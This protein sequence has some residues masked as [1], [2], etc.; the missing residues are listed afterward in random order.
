M[1]TVIT[2]GDDGGPGG[3]QPALLPLGLKAEDVGCP[4]CVET[5]TDPFVTS[6]GHTFCYQ[7]IT[8][9]L[10]HKNSCP[11]CGAYLTVD[12]IYPNFLLNKILRKAAAAPPPG[13]SSLLDQVQRLLADNMPAAEPLLGS[14]GASSHGAGVVTSHSSGWAGG[15]GLGSPG[16]G[17]GG[18]GLGAAAFGGRQKLRLRLRDIDA[19]LEA[20]YD[21][22]EELERRD[23]SDVLHL[24]LC[25]LQHA[26]EHKARQ[27]AQLR[28]QLQFLDHDIAAVSQAGQGL[29][30]AAA[31]AEVTGGGAAAAAAAALE[32]QVAAAAAAAAATAAAAAAAAPAVE[33]LVVSG[34]AGRLP[35]AVVGAP[36]ATAAAAAAGTATAPHSP[37]GSGAAAW[38][39]RSHPHLGLHPPPQPVA[40]LPPPLLRSVSSGSIGDAVD[41]AAAAAAAAAGPAP[42]SE[43]AAEPPRLR[44][45][46]PPPVR[47]ASLHLHTLMSG[48]GISSFTVD[49]TELERD[50]QAAALSAAVQ[51]A[52]AAAAR[53]TSAGGGSGS[54]SVSVSAAASG[55]AGA[56]C[57]TARAGAE[58]DGHG[59][60]SRSLSAGPSGPPRMGLAAA[61]AAAGGPAAAVAALRRMPR[62]G[63]A[64]NFQLLLQHHTSSLV[65]GLGGGGA[66]PAP[67][68]DG[69][70]SA[71]AASAGGGGGAEEDSTLSAAAAAAASAQHSAPRPEA[72]AA[73]AA[74]H[75]P[76]PGPSSSAAAA[77]AG[78]HG[79]PTANGHANGRPLMANGH[80]PTANGNAGRRKRDE[81]DEDEEDEMDVRE[82]R[83]G[84]GRPA[85]A[86][87][88]QPP[89]LQPSQPP[90]PAQPPAVRQ[91]TQQEVPAPVPRVA[92]ASC[93]GGPEGEGEGEVDLAAVQA[94]KRRRMLSQFDVLEKCY[95][96]MRAA[97]TSYNGG[98]QTDGDAPP[99]FPLPLPLPSGAVDASAPPPSLA[100]PRP[101]ADPA[102]TQP[103]AFPH[104]L[105][106]GLPHALPHALPNGHGHGTAA[107]DP[108]APSEGAA[109]AALHGPSGHWAQALGHHPWAD[110][111]GR[112]HGAGL[113]PD[114]GG[115][116]AG[117]A[118]GEGAGAGLSAF[119][120][121][122]NGSGSGEAGAAGYP[123]GPGPGQGQGP[124][125]ESAQGE[126]CG[127]AH[128]HRAPEGPGGTCACD[129]HPPLVSGGG[130]VGVG[131][132]AAL[133]ATGTGAIALAAGGRLGSEPDPDLS[134]FGAVLAAATQYSRLEMLAEIPRWTGSGSGPGGG[135]PAAAG[136]GGGGAATT[137]TPAGGL[138][139]L[140]S[141][142]FDLTDTLFATAGVVPRILVYDYQALLAS[143][144]PARPA[145]ELSCR[146]KL[147]CL[148]YSQAERQHLLA[149]DYQ[150][151]VTL[152]DTAVG[153]Q[154]QDWEAHERRVWGVDFSPA[155]PHTFAS[156]SD[157][158]MVKVWNTR[159]PSSCLALELRG[160]VCCV[161][162][163]PTDP[164]LLAVGS[165]L[166]CAV[167]YDV[168][169]PSAPLHTLLGH[170][171]A[172]SYVRWLSNRNELVTAST[173]STLKLWSL[174]ASSSATAAVGGGGGAGLA[175]APSGA[176][177]S[178][179][180]GGGAEVVRTFSGHVNERNFVGLSTDG[181]YIA[182]GSESHEVFV[183]Y[184]SIPQP[185]LSY[186]FPSPVAAAAPAAAGAQPQ[187]FV[188]AL[189]WRRN[190]P[191]LLAANSAGSVWLLGLQL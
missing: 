161:E 63:S 118:A 170:R 122:S 148:S 132:A 163:H 46:R 106:H 153:M 58:E 88:G 119:A 20:L 137:G 186:K 182:C 11:S 96:Q 14:T 135:A 105:S 172:V 94:A 23:S 37:S 157:D 159:Q 124:G 28:Q 29:A 111:L 95:L 136:A 49:A 173:D 109:A 2:D 65:G 138:Q 102:H 27:L 121:L 73:T 99:A 1:S 62:C 92:R 147:S 107:A 56:A 64:D 17:L 158:G 86:A 72:T 59:A 120:R 139:I 75:G 180:S 33:A 34:P 44:A 93:D 40:P 5:I 79:K 155:S 151:G 126:A 90:P 142:E 176:G 179:S 50:Q 156:G 66:Q 144:A 162:W 104:A 80:R 39:H 26:R 61:A 53:A 81:D 18:G 185:A 130:G 164:N 128:P 36:A 22:R 101:S 6:C 112:Q 123:L 74:T 177:G 25:F 131:T 181:D 55:G 127:G 52:L 71:G 54:V 30:G 91:L 13:S 51:Q 189:T 134:I 133:A 100:G 166:H 154:V 184:R 169:Q 24:L 69:C 187:H 3:R 78:L 98:T 110:N 165:A 183:Y 103:H 32:D 10:R 141:I 31:A 9:Q 117:A 188:T 116:G 146:T 85:A 38:L 57:G 82:R 67:S 4:I 145:S 143:R 83:R 60:D 174:S 114:A 87:N 76:G 97:R 175:A 190:S 89:A 15:A 129:R 19:V 150:G 152:W 8:T 191:H 47:R 115:S 16:S 160:N 70:E 140:S 7:C 108:S 125:G 171:K 167:V 42:P 68:S 12:H 43:A 84:R 168:R 21:A 149:A 77:A 48:G 113:A 178:D 45:Q 35:L 41:A